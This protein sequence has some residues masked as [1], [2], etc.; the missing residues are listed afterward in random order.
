MKKKSSDNKDIFIMLIGIGVVLLAFISLF[1]TSQKGMM[2]S[3]VS[4]LVM[5]IGIFITIWGYNS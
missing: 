2:A 4:I 1:W 3:A 5:I